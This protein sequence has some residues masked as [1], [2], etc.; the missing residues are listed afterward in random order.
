MIPYPG[1]S[2]QQ[3]ASNRLTDAR[4]EHIAATADL[5]A[6]T[7]RPEPQE[8]TARNS[9]LVRLEQVRAAEQRTAH[10]LECAE[11]QV[12]GRA[13]SPLARFEEMKKQENNNVNNS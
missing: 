3:H 12:A 4:E 8:L 1:P 11:N 2:P 5:A 7:S 10:E 6:I 9:Y 13:L